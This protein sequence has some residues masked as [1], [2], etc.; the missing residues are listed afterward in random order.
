MSGNKRQLFIDVL[1]GDDK[2]RLKVE[3]AT[4]A[5]EDGDGNECELTIATTFGL[6]G[7]WIGLTGHYQ[8]EDINEQ[9]DLRDLFEQWVVDIIADIND[10]VNR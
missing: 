7:T 6:G 1:E 8:G 9:F 2:M 10:E 5:V 4:V 3:A